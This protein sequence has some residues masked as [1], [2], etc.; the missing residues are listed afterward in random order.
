MKNRKF[1]IQSQAA[2]NMIA[3]FKSDSSI[4][5]FGKSKVNGGYA[6]LE[7]DEEDFDLFGKILINKPGIPDWKKKIICY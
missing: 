7:K 6:P 3:E 5:L 2:D 1:K 4:D